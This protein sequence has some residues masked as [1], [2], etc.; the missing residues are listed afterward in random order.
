[1]ALVDKTKNPGKTRKQVFWQIST[2]DQIQ[3]LKIQ[4]DV[5]KI[6]GLVYTGADVT[7][8]SPKS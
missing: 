2:R 8:I 7:I 4:I 3:K 1:M 6:E 5:I